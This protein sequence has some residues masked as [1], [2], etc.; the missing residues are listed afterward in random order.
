[1]EQGIKVA[2][3]L[4]NVEADSRVA[5]EQETIVGREAEEVNKMAFDIKIIADDA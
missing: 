3:A 4:K 1:M 2:E 5:N